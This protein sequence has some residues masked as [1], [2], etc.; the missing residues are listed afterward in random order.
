MFIIT[1]LVAKRA[2]VTTPPTGQGQR[3]QH[4]PGQRQKFQ[5]LSAGGRYASYWNAFLFQWKLE[6]YEWASFQ[7]Q[8]GTC[9]L[10]SKTGSDVGGLYNQGLQ[11]VHHFEMKPLL[12]I[13]FHVFFTLERLICNFTFRSSYA[14][15]EHIPNVKFPG[16]KT[17]SMLIWYK[18]FSP[19]S[20]WN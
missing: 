14:F 11:E 13:I 6:I 12:G 20:F 17:P 16:F 9:I 18:M 1:A 15:Y 8:D 7:I 5:H 10:S 4:P 19:I 3:P 2:N